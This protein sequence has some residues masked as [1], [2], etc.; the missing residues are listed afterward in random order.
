MRK[1]TEGTLA[2]LYHLRIEALLEGGGESGR[3]EGEKDKM[4]VFEGLE[5]AGRL[6]MDKEKGVSRAGRPKRRPILSGFSFYRRKVGQDVFEFMKRGYKEKE[7]EGIEV[8]VR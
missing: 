8:R 6:V 5:R 4:G 1:Y 3:K 7:Y 2:R